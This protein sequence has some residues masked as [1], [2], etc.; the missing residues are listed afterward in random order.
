MTHLTLAL[1]TMGGDYGPHNIVPALVQA[2]EHFTSVDFILVGDKQLLSSLL[3]R[4]RIFSHKRITITH[5]D[6]VVSMTDKPSFALRHRKNS[7]MRVALEL[8]KSGQADACVSSGNTGALMAMAKVILKTLP[9]IERPALISGLPTI[10]DK[11]VYMLDLGANVNCSATMLFQFGVMGSVL[12]EVAEQ[13]PAP[14][15]ALLNIGSEEIKGNEPVQQAAKLLKQASH[16]N[17]V[18]FIEGDDIFRGEHDVIVCD[19][20]VGNTTLKASEGVARLLTN[21]LQTTAKSSWFFKMLTSL[22]RPVLTSALKKMNPDHYNGASLLGLRGVVVKSHGGADEKAFY[23][24]IAH[25]VIEAERKLP[26]LIC[27]R[28]QS[29]LAT[30]EHKSD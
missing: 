8:V 22:M 20:F 2:L 21:H 13:R 1:D 3:R 11:P 10:A 7:S 14:K 27:H 18:G 24:A 17:Y 29:L 16:I 4:H 6:Q 15:V 19:G 30:K 28:V 23:Q 12:A 9:G 25:A 5:T 26:D